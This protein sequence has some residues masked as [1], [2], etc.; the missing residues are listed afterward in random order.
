MRQTNIALSH[1]GPRAA[2]TAA[3][4]GVLLLG[5]GCDT[6]STEPRYPYDPG[7]VCESFQPGATVKVFEEAVFV[8]STREASVHDLAADLAVLDRGYAV[9]HPH[10]TSRV[11]LRAAA[12]LPRRAWAPV[13][14]AA[15]AAGLERVDAAPF[16]DGHRGGAPQT[17][18]TSLARKCSVHFV[19]G[20][21]P[22]SVPMSRLDD[23]GALVALAAHEPGFTLDPR[24]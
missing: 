19:F 11:E 22:G 3:L 1:T 15:F 13:V 20:E 24:R 5:A 17:L 6:P 21:G 2:L 12:G 10:G 23:W 14:G 8:G 16:R 7:D 18:K 4:A 9:L